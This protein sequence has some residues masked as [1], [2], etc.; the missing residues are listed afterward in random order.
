MQVPNG[1]DH[2][3]NTFRHDR[4]AFWPRPLGATPRGRPLHRHGALG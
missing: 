4:L 1:G 3:G 2:A